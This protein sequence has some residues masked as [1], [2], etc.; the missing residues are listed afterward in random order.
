M[1]YFYILLILSLG[2]MGC[3]TNQLKQFD[4]VKVGMDKGDVL[5]LMGSPQKTLRW[6][7]MDRWS[8]Q[9]WQDDQFYNKEVHFNESVSKYVG[10]AFKPEV[11]AEQQDQINEASNKDLE[12]QALAKKQEL[13]K[14]YSDYESQVRGEN[15]IRYVPTFSPVE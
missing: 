5:G 9:F 6:H 10:E 12:A 7:G 13:R 1:R 15:Q 11:S 3:Q 14:E 2:L 4:K 8:Y